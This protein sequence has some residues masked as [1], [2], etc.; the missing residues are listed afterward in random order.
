MKTPH[1]IPG[2]HRG[3]AAMRGKGTQAV[4]IVSGVWPWILFPAHCGRSARRE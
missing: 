2:E 3:I 1:V 4:S